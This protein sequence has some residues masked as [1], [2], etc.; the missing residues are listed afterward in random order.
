MR[1]G[2]WPVALEGS[3]QMPSDSWEEWSQYVLKELQRLNDSI[4]ALRSDLIKVRVNDLVEL[5]TEI[6]TL[7]AKA[8][9]W[10]AVG[11]AIPVVVF[12]AWEA[13]KH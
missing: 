10:G 1:R 9:L 5:K 11:A 6:A 4:D 8:G 7:K 3:T 12:I 13:L 2:D